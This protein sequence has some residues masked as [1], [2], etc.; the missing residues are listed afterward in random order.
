M[1]KFSVFYI[2]E[3]ERLQKEIWNKNV[4]GFNKQEIKKNF[5]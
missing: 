2:F 5:A 3:N 1:R 4:E